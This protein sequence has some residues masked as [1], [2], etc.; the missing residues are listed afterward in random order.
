M[1]P[2]GVTVRPGL[3]DQFV[4]AHLGRPYRARPFVVAGVDKGAGIDHFTVLAQQDAR[5]EDVMAV[6]EDVHPHRYCLAHDGLRRV[7]MG[8]R[9][10]QVLH[11]DVEERTRRNRLRLLRLGTGR[12]PGPATG[13]GVSSLGGHGPP[14]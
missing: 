14:T 9:R 11:N 13:P 6:F 4:K 8:S 2:S 12:H 5:G 7:A 1:G 3:H 10:A